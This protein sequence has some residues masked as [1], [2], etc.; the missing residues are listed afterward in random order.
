MAKQIPDDFLNQLR[1]ISIIEIAETYFQLKK[2]SSIFQTSCI[3]G[4]DSDP[5]LTFFP[6]TNTFYCFGCGAGKRPKTEGSDPISFVMWIDKCTFMEA[7]AKLANMKGLVVPKAQL[8]A[9]D[10]KKQQLYTQALEENRSYWDT[11]QDP[12]YHDYLHY[13]EERGIKKEDVDKWRLGAVRIDAMHRFPGRIAFSLMNDWGQTVGFSYRNMFEKIPCGMPPDDRAK[14][15]NSS[16]ST[17]FDKGSILYGLHFVKRMIRE[18]GYVVIGE[19][20]GDSILGQKVGLPFVSIMGT[21]LTDQHIQILK[22][23]T[24][25]VILWLD[26]DTGGIT[27]TTRHAKALRQNGFIVKVINYL[28]KDPDDIFLSIIND[29][30]CGEETEAYVEKLVM[31]ESVLA[32][33]FEIDRVLTQY[34][35][36]LTELKMRTIR[37]IYPVL[38]E[39]GTVEETAFSKSMI[40]KRLGVSLK[41]FGWEVK[42]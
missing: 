27:A 4:G 32:S 18:K 25:T 28:G 8:S 26:G 39:I 33:Q 22:Q 34:E 6:Q 20:F 30:G 41:E 1:S 17:I 38:E 2:T 9:E 29:M 5:S 40:V 12:A 7:I 36:Q 24:D 15:I 14:Y 13:L 21:S 19:G 37:N 16:K 10:K 31:T 11:L 3:H 35:S 23:Y 42:E